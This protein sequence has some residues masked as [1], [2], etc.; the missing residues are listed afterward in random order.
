MAIAV[1]LLLHVPPAIGE[2]KVVFPPTQTLRGV[3]VVVVKLPASMN[4]PES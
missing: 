1:L 2:V 4:T 3:I